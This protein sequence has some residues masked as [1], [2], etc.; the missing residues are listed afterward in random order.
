ML[1]T[2][3]AEESNLSITKNIYFDKEEKERYQKK[4][5]KMKDDKIFREDVDFEDLKWIVVANDIDY[6]ISMEYN[7]L[8]LRKALN[9][10][11]INITVQ[12][13]IIGIKA[14]VLN[15]LEYSAPRGLHHDVRFLHKMIDKVGFFEPQKSQEFKSMMKHASDVSYYGGAISILDFIGI[16]AP[17][18][19]YAI[20]YEQ[21][22]ALQYKKK[23]RE[24][25]DFK[26]IFAFGEVVKDFTETA[27]Q[28]EFLKYGVVSIWWQICNRIPLRP[29][30]FV[31]LPRDCVFK[32]DDKYYIRLKRNNAKGPASRKNII[33]EDGII[34]T[35]TEDT[36]RVDEDLFNLI[37]Y[38]NKIMDE[39]YPYRDECYLFDKQF[40]EERV[41]ERTFK[42]Q[43]NKN[44]F[45]SYN[46]RNT[47]YSFYED[48]VFLKYKKPICTKNQKKTDYEGIKKNK[49]YRVK[50]KDHIEMLVP[51]DLRHV[52]IINL[53]MMG[54]EPLTVMRMAH[55][56]N[57]RITKGYYDH[58]NEY[59]KSYIQTYSKYLRGVKYNRTSVLSDDGQ[60][61]IND[62]IGEDNKNSALALWHFLDD[63]N[64]SN[65]SYKNVDG[66]ICKYLKED[67]KPC[68]AV[69]GN[70][71]ICPY[72]VPDSSV[73]IEKM[74]KFENKEI[75]AIL[76][77]INYLVENHNTI[78]N[79]SR[80]YSV[81]I[82]SYR[83]ELSNASM[84]ASNLN[85]EDKVETLL[86]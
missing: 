84:I 62:I 35:Y 23:T 8:T 24:L 53:I 27:T 5:Q 33:N 25:P 34:D 15:A 42:K 81:A 69:E 78:I 29:T 26:S 58:M 31:L 66:G 63:N 45:T 51:Y 56:K 79:F 11:E 17:E 12:D 43:L 38:Y 52:A 72:F 7:E 71:S 82:E 80:K 74:F 68:Y 85:S 37:S 48:I 55:H 77:T 47:I 28:D 70:H 6:T 10:S 14:Y 20:W 83:N 46:L 54:C 9:T 4:F 18:E 19:Y 60:V 61:N 50:Y 86:Q 21:L 75:N 13:L 49:K 40:Y 73:D 2:M 41:L 32:K 59:G 3:I 30:E 65:V 36:L 57:I 44:R 22:D 39:K 67:L 1:V 16:P 76:D 64:S